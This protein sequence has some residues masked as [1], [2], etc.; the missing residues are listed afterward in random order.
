MHD[1]LYADI[2]NIKLNF[3]HA[4]ERILTY[5]YISSFLQKLWKQTINSMKTT[6]N[7][8]FYALIWNLSAYYSR[9]S[10]GY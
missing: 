4:Y 1:L 6:A 8:L 2:R 3:N 9:F 10:V 7:I 5:V